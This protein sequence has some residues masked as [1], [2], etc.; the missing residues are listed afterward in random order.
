MNYM[1]VNKKIQIQ[2]VVI[3]LEHETIIRTTKIV[4]IKKRKQLI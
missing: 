3:I 1:I 4:Q 2:W